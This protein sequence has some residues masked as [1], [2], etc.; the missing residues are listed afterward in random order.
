MV[1]KQKNTEDKILI[2]AKEVFIQKGLDGARMQEIADTAGI[3]KALLHYYYRT[4]DK[5]FDKVFKAAFSLFIPKIR[6]AIT[7]NS[8]LFEFIKL[9]VHS[10]IDLINKNQFIPGFIIGELRRN[11]DRVVTIFS[12]T[13][14]SDRI[15]L[16]KQVQIIVDNH[17]I[18]G[19]IKPIKP[20]HLL[21]NMI[22]LCVFPVIAKP[23]IEGV[24]LNSEMDD[25]NSFMSERKKVVVDFIIN[26][27]RI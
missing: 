14:G 17:V 26:S 20:I 7:E 25:Y 4:K 18:K 5:L 3:N 10:Y 11:P 8:D 16:L 24:L 21:V 15:E 22:A 27:I 1:D 9:F 2:A 6:E 12:E 23:I 13:I 19:L